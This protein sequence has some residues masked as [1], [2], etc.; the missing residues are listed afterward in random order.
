MSPLASVLKTPAIES[1]DATEA[2]PTEAE[3]VEA[4]TAEDVNLDDTLSKIDTMLLDAAAEEA[5]AATEE[6]PGIV[7]GKGMEKA[8]D[9]SEEED[10]TFQDILGQELSK[11]EKEELKEYAISCRYRP[12]ALLF[13]GV[14]EES[15]GYLWDQTGAKVVG[16]ISKSVG[17]TKVEADLSRY[18]RQHIAGSLFYANFKVKFLT[19]HCFDMKIVF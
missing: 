13:G 1:T 16:T 11:A 5:T 18:R 4:E 14:N 19:F 2:A 15:L 9:I 6:I 12:G 3:S 8:E 10:F 7:A 17:L